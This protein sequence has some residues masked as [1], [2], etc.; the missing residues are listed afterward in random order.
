MRKIDLIQKN[1][2]QGREDKRFTTT[3]YHS[4]S[5]INEDGFLFRI[6][7]RELR[8]I[9]GGLESIQ[10]NHERTRGGWRERNTQWTSSETSTFSMQVVWADWRRGAGS[11]T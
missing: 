5:R 4:R 2:T 3:Y 7:C 6:S 8:A 11:L 1:Y 9:H 10:G